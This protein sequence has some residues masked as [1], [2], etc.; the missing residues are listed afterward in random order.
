[1]IY[2]VLK[3]NDEYNLNYDE[4][5]KKFTISYKDKGNHGFKLT[6]FGGGELHDLPDK[7]TLIN[8]LLNRAQIEYDIKEKCQWILREEPIP[9]EALRKMER[10]G[11]KANITE[12]VEDILLSD[13][14]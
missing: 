2:T 3:E 9:E 13:A 11:A 5:G 10:I 1:M 14:L 4:S 8:K 7:I 12:A 6:I